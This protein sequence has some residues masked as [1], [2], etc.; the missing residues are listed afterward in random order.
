MPQSEQS[1][2][3]DSYGFDSSG[4]HRNGTLY[5]DAGYDAKGFF[6]PLVMNMLRFHRNGTY[7]IKMA[8]LIL[9]LIEICD[10]ELREVNLIQMGL[11][12]KDLMLRV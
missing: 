5:D 3:Y 9:A 10:I 8:T 1:P 12:L 4:L 7:L 2:I 11:T 6:R